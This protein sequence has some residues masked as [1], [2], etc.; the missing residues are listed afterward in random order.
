MQ[1]FDFRK[2]LDSVVKVVLNPDAFK[3][4]VVAIRNSMQAGLRVVFLLGAVSM[5]ISFLLILTVPE[6]SRMRWSR[7]KRLRSLRLQRRLLN[8]RA[9]NPAYHT[10]SGLPHQERPSDEEGWQDD[11]S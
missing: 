4:T 7:I 9:L 1:D 8:K 11:Y 5:L 2:D 6:I 10:G 3:P